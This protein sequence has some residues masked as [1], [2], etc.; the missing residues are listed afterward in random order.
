MILGKGRNYVTNIINY[1]PN[2]LPKGSF[3]KVGDK[4]YI[5]TE[6]GIE[7]LRSQTENKNKKKE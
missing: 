5:I 4:T 7:A 6:E 3:K 2:R 1:Y